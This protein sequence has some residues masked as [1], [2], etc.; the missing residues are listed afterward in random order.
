M[1]LGRVCV[2]PATLRPL[3][4]RGTADTWAVRPQG[5]PLAPAPPAAIIMAMF[6]C[7]AVE[8]MLP[9]AR[10]TYPKLGGTPL[11]R[12]EEEGDPCL[13]EL[14]LPPPPMLRRDGDDLSDFSTF[15]PLSGSGILLQLSRP[16]RDPGRW[17]GLP[18]ILA[19]PPELL[20]L[21]LLLFWAWVVVEPPLEL[22]WLAAELPF[23]AVP[24]LSKEPRLL[25]ILERST[26]SGLFN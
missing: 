11:V 18:S 14:P 24:M 7:S 6:C 26:E 8:A 10:F 17:W 15:W 12:E 3:A 16:F 19:P 4:V 1:S 23:A 2:P 20:L 9:L 25:R 21:L 5:R 22:A 13:E